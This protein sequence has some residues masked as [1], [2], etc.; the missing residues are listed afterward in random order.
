MKMKKVLIHDYHKEV[1]H[2]F[3]P[4]F[5]VDR[6]T[7][8]GKVL[9]P[10]STIS[11]VYTLK[12]TCKKCLNL[13]KGLQPKPRKSLTPNNVARLI[14]YWHSKTITEWAKEFD[15]TYQTVLKFVILIRKESPTLCVKDSKKYGRATRAIVGLGIDLYERKNI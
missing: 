10:T 14:K 9:P 1:I 13:A 7:L 8:C 11:H 5:K 6:T 3:K 2:Y 15:V 4:P 12:V